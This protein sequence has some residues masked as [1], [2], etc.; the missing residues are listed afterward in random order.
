[1]LGITEQTCYRCRNG[2]G[3][4]KIHQV[5]RLA[6]LTLDEPT[7]NEAAQGNF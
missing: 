3:D 7:L 5:K 4:L 6:D 1:M 2:Y